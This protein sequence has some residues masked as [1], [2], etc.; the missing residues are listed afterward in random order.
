MP[1]APTPKSTTK[2]H[3][4]VFSR[5]GPELPAVVVKRPG[6]PIWGL[7]GSILQLWALAHAS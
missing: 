2:G 4:A 3:G 7:V 6:G 5:T 1:A